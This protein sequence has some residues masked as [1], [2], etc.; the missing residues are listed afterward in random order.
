MLQMKLEYQFYITCIFTHVA[1]CYKLARKNKINK[2][3]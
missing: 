2:N 3:S 1:H